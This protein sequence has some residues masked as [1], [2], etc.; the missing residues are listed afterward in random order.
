[1]ET[2]FAGCYYI[3]RGTLNLYLSFWQNLLGTKSKLILRAS[4]LKDHLFLLKLGASRVEFLQLDCNH[5][6]KSQVS[7]FIEHGLSQDKTNHYQKM[8]I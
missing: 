8:T 5:C 3:H 1:M 4:R 7:L 2:D 6:K